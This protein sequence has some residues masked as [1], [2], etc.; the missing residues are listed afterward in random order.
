MKREQITETNAREWLG[1]QQLIYASHPASGDRRLRLI[2]WP[3]LQTWEVHI[4]IG[5]V[6]DELY[7]GSDLRQAVKVFNRAQEGG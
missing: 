5:G 6:D 1:K 3:G 7:L 2:Y 4:G